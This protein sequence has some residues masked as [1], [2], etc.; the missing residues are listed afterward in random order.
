MHFLQGHTF[1]VVVY[2]FCSAQHWLIQLDTDDQLCQTIQTLQNLNIYN[3]RA[4]SPMTYHRPVEWLFGPLMYRS[5]HTSLQVV[6]CRACCA[7][8]QR[9]QM[10]GE[11]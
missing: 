5:W 7:V 8:K 9:K 1:V 11:R 3:V 2:L 6:Q 4:V 10:T